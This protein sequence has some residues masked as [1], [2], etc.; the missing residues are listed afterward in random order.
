M[1]HS[2]KSNSLPTLIKISFKSGQQGKKATN[3]PMLLLKEQIWRLKRLLQAVLKTY[4][5]IQ[6]NLGAALSP[7]GGR[8]ED[9][10][11]W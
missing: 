3:G 5:A 7:V 9:K 10:R 6:S 8:S 1:Y 2:E 11:H 4:M